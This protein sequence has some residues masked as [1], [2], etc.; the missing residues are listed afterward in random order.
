MLSQVVHC[1]RKQFQKLN[2][3]H[4]SAFWKTSL[5]QRQCLS[6][7]LWFYQK[8]DL[9]HLFIKLGLRAWF[10][11]FVLMSQSQWW[12]LL[13]GRI[14]E[15][16]RTQFSEGWL[17]SELAFTLRFFWVIFIVPVHQSQLSARDWR[18]I[19]ADLIWSLFVQYRQLFVLRRSL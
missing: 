7:V 10:R 8:S 3:F 12:R 5:Y 2:N 1:N 18:W 11:W 19:N 13:E 14:Y 16:H 9:L 4:V 15:V 17:N 6:E